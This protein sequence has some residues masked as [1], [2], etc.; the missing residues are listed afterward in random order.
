MNKPASLESAA[1]HSPLVKFQ[2]F[3]TATLLFSLGDSHILTDGFFSRPD[4]LSVLLGKIRPQIQKISHCLSQASVAHL[5]AVLVGHSH[6]DHAL[7]AP[8]VATLTHA[9]LVGSPS[10]AQ[11]ARGFGLPSEKIVVIQP[12]VQLQFGS[13]QVTFISSCHSS[14]NLFPGE[15]KLPF[16]SPARVSAY[17]E[18]G[19]YSILIQARSQSILVHGSA[20]FIPGFLENTR[21]QTVFLSVASLSRVSSHFLEQ[22]FSETILATQARWVYPIHWDDFQAPAGPQLK[23]PPAWIDDM[24]KTM[25]RLEDFCIQHQVNFSVPPYAKSLDL[26]P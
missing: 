26:T 2:Y 23:Y 20:G 4:R 12:G 22:Y 15:I 24:R 16:P 14:P 10:T 21:A 9:Q 6:Y 1:F 13:F 3:G 19:S 7:D 25:R 5:D 8:A 11:I 18:G 17:C